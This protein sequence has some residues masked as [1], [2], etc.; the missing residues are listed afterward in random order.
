MIKGK[1]KKNKDYRNL[2]MSYYNLGNFAESIDSAEAY[3]HKAVAISD[4]L[5]YY[6]LLATSYGKLRISSKIMG[7]LIR[8]K[9]LSS[10]HRGYN[11]V[12]LTHALIDIGQIYVI[13]KQEDSSE[14]YFNLAIENFYQQKPITLSNF[15]TMMV[16]QQDQ[17]LSLDET[18]FALAKEK[19]KQL[20]GLE[21]F[22][23]QLA[24][25][26]NMK[27]KMQIKQLMGIVKDYKKFKK[28]LNNLT[29]LYVEGRVH[30][31]YQMSKKGMGKLKKPLLYDRNITMANEFDKVV[32]EQ[33]LFCAIGAGHLSGKKGVLKLLKDKGYK[34]KPVKLKGKIA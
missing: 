1:S 15:L 17:S 22:D 30:Q 5:D 20:V 4:S 13:E 34:V 9:V 10:Y 27:M 11:Y 18:L 21:T 2:A 7:L 19:N 26:K 3:F 31:L 16:F 6:N 29:N 23:D 33:T 24:I 28:S 8:K 32:Q 25:M 12:G 14:Y